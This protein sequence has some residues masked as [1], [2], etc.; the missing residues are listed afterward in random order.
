MK[1]IILLCWFAGLFATTYFVSPSGSDFNVGSFDNPFATIGAAIIASSD[2]DLVIVSEG[3]YYENNID[4]F[5]KD[6][7][8]QGVNK[9]TTIVDG[10]GSGPIFYFSEGSDE[11]AELHGFTITNGGRAIKALSSH[12]YIHDLI[13]TGNII[14]YQTSDDGNE[15]GAIYLNNSNSNQLI[16]S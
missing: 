4:F 9:E 1:K 3:T 12:P 8:V 6:I 11:T 5:G 16:Q 15:S 13:I 14:N 10:G 7:E 2:G